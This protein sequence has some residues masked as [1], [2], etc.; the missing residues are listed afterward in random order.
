M[1]ISSGRSHVEHLAIQPALPCHLQSLEIAVYSKGVVPLTV[2]R[3]KHSFQLDCGFPV[4]VNRKPRL[5]RGVLCS[6]AAAGE[7]VCSA[8]RA[9]PGMSLAAVIF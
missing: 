1:Y 8:C 7:Q 9:K 6:C 5:T 2:K 3:D 4:S